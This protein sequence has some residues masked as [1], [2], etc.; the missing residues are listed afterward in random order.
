[1]AKTLPVMCKQRLVEVRDADAAVDADVVVLAA[2]CEN[3][4]PET[5]L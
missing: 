4:N 1:M 2:Y 3:P 5:V